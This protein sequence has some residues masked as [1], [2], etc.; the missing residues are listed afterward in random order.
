MAP[1]RHQLI[2]RREAVGHTQESL[3]EALQVDRTTVGRWENGR[4][5]PQPW[6]RPKLAQALRVSLDQLSLLLSGARRPE[7]ASGA[8]R[9]TT[10]RASAVPGPQPIHDTRPIV[11]AVAADSAD[12]ALFLRFASASNVDEHLVGAA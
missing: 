5:T 12:S 1:K 9:I 3:A 10:Y 4:G 2:Q 8:P 7:A 11:E 6:M